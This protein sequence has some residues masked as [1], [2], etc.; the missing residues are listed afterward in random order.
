M[1]YHWSICFNDF[2][3]SNN[4]T[5]HFSAYRWIITAGHCLTQ[6]IPFNVSLG[7]RADGTYETTVMVNVSDQ[8]IYPGFFNDQMSYDIGRQNMSTTSD[9]YLGQLKMYE[10]LLLLLLLFQ[11]AWSDCRSQFN[12]AK[13]FSQP[14]CRKVVRTWKHMKPWIQLVSGSGFSVSRWFFRMDNCERDHSDG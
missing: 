6:N 13:P 10:I 2:F 4:A 9:S 14:N 11:K 3:I 5:K 7:I 1:S 8:H 12:W